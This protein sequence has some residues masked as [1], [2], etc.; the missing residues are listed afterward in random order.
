MTIEDSDEE[1]EVSLKYI[2]KFTVKSKRLIFFIVIVTLQAPVANMAFSLYREIG[3]YFKERGVFGA[4][5]G[6]LVGKPMDG[7]FEEDYKDARIR[8]SYDTS[9]DAPVKIKSW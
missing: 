5:S 1:E 4:V 6:V 3:E 7:A 8:I 2:L 9:L